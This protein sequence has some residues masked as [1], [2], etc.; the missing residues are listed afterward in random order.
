MQR[1]QKRLRESVLGS[2]GF[3]VVSVALLAQGSVL[4]VVVG[5]VGVVTFMGFGIT[6]LVLYRR[7]GPGLIVDD[8]GFDDRS[9][10]VAVGRVSWSDVTWIS[11]LETFGHSS[12]VVHVG[13]PDVYLA[14]LALLARLVARANLA[15]V[16]SPVAISPR[17]LEIGTEDLIALMQQAFDRNQASASRD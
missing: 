13:N 8:E 7:R 15:M 6:A 2:I 14:R 9:S 12:L 4:G 10:P 5:S 17:N 11:Q 3:V 1:S 16:G